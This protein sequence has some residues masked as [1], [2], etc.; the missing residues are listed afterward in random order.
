MAGVISKRGLAAGLQSV[1]LPEGIIFS[2]TGRVALAPRQRGGDAAVFKQIGDQVAQGR[3]AVPRIASP[4]SIPTSMS[5]G[6]SFPLSIATSGLFLIF[7]RPGRM[8]RPARCQKLQADG[9]SEV[10]GRS[11][12]AAAAR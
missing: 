11:G 3:A 4:V 7:R 10:A 8:S 12:S 2:A 6:F 1:A 5:H 9:S